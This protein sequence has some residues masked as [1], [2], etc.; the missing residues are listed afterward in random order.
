MKS[1]YLII[2]S[3]VT[4][5][6]AI[7]Q[8]SGIWTPYYSMVYQRNAAP[9][10]SA[11]ITFSGQVKN[12]TNVS[13]RIWRLDKYG[14]QQSPDWKPSQALPAGAMSALGDGGIY[15]FTLDVPTG[16]YVFEVSDQVSPA[17]WTK[18]GVG[19]VFVIAGQSNAQGSDPVQRITT[20]ENLDCVVGNRNSPYGDFGDLWTPIFT[21]ISPSA[22][23]IGPRGDR[24][25]FWQELGNKIVTREAPNRIIPVAFYNMAHGGSSITNWHDSMN[26]VKQM[27]SNNYAN[28]MVYGTTVMT[29]NPWGFSTFDNR[30]PY[31]DMR[32]F[33]TYYVNIT[34]VRAVLWHQGEAETKTLLS[35]NRK[36][37]YNPG[38]VPA[39]YSIL[40][41]DTKLKAIIADTRTIHPNLHWAI[42]K[43]SLNGQQRNPPSSIIDTHYTGK[44]GTT[45]TLFTPLGD[46]TI[47]ASVIDEQISVQST[48]SN[49]SWMS[50][51][52]DSYT[53]R[54]PDGTHFSEA[55]LVSMANEVYG[56]MGTILAATPILPTPSLPKLT[57]T[58][59]ASLDYTASTSG[60]FA[61][62]RWKNDYGA[63]A[64]EQDAATM[65]NNY[66]PTPPSGDLGFS[67][68]VKSSTGKIYQVV[69]WVYVK[70]MPGARMSVE[71]QVG[72][73]ILE[74]TSIFPNPL[75]KEQ[76]LNISFSTT[77]S[78]PMTI[79]L[80][81]SQ[82]LVLKK[83]TDDIGEGKHNYSISLK[84]LNLN[85]DIQFIYYRL[86]TMQH[87]E[88]KRV[89]IAK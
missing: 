10:G 11:V 66:N 50:Q 19:E 72:S 85:Q 84:E 21:A 61:F 7:A 26:R 37:K 42:S 82:G 53:P 83:F 31:S 56:N 47:L 29:T 74:S 64:F 63:F 89:L 54:S 65:G 32:D 14:V 52:S 79:M 75:S 22:P 78:T 76:K 39:G 15:H 68:Y 73:P 17:R 71:S 55:N 9:G 86:E 45:P 87:N 35:Q 25:W 51:N 28:M 20:S 38:P 18:F 57:L 44:V 24:P 1:I 2:I 67:G 40:D 5:F 4:S 36:T 59:N 43:V 16:W 80:L 8:D 62:Y 81:N 77:M 33:L 70:Y 46:T 3:V 69:P 48:T 13:Y 6:C 27:Y 23:K 58:K 60:G 41:Y 49:V 34:G 12:R 88:T 30:L